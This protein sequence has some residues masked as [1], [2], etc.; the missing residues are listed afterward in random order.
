MK[1]MSDESKSFAEQLALEEYKSLKEEMQEYV[2]ESYMLEL[3]G[4]GALG[5][6]YSWYLFQNKPALLAFIP[7]VLVGYGFRRSVL[8]L[9][10]IE[11]IAEYIRNK[12]ELTP[13][14]GWETYFNKTRKQ[15]EM[16][17]HVK[18]IWLLLL[19]ITL[20]I[21]VFVFISQI[22]ICNCQCW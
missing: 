11:H 16:S 7:V 4:I 5:A 12:I 9:K 10:R 6:F 17:R 1:I 20:V 2:K 21:A 13:S 22:H 14:H 15:S 3:Y 19:V 18:A 8:L